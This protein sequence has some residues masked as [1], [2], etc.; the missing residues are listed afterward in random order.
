MDWLMQDWREIIRAPWSEIILTIVAVLCGLL[1]GAERERKEK[2]AG[3]RTM[4]LVSLGSSAFTMM[5]LAIAGTQGD[6]GRIASQ[7][8]PGIGFLGA[9]AILRGPSGVT[10]LT[11]AATIWAVA[12]AGMLVGAGFGSAGLALSLVIVSV[13][14]GV[15]LLERRYQ[16]PCELATAVLVFDPSGGKAAIAIEEI[17]D[18]SRVPNPRVHGE[19]ARD[20]LH[21]AR[22]EFCAAHKLHKEVLVRLAAVPEIREIRQERD[23]PTN[24]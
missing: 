17:L 20:G 5:S 14:V 22:I 9:G 11:T 4:A 23:H 7:I 13:L 24:L 18:E 19:P 3:L 1:V 15:S 6:R 16:G 21:Q 8:V 10:G 2:P 12:A